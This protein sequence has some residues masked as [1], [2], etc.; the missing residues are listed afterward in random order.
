[1]GSSLQFNQHWVIKSENFEFVIFLQW[2]Y[3]DKNYGELKL[4]NTTLI[5]AKRNA[6]IEY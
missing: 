2:L 6:P 4:L 5:I 3:Y 1:M